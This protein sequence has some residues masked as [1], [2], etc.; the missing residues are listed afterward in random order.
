M[1]AKGIRRFQRGAQVGIGQVWIRLFGSVIPVEDS[2]VYLLLNWR[3]TGKI[4]AAT[5]PSWPWVGIREAI[6]NLRPRL[7]R[8]RFLRGRWAF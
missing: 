8:R 1:E 6:G 2:G 3:V 7:I 4:V 5:S